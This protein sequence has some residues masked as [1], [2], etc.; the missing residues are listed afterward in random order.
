MEQKRP[1]RTNRLIKNRRSPRL[2]PKKIQQH[3]R[4]QQSS[5]PNP[6]SHA[7]HVQIDRQDKNRRKTDHRYLGHNLRNP[8]EDPGVLPMV[9]L[10]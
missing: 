2:S 8:R 3:S 10:G 5:K 7:L 6:R 9:Q 4:I 1:P